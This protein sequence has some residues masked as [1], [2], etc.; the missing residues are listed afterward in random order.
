MHSLVFLLFASVVHSY[1]PLKPGTNL[2]EEQFL[3]NRN[4]TET[5]GSGEEIEQFL[6]SENST[7][8]SASPTTTFPSSS[9]PPV[10]IKCYDI[11]KKCSKIKSL[12]TR[13]EYRTIMVRQCAKTCDACAQF[14]RLPHAARCRDSFHSC[15]IWAKNGFC[16]TTY[17][18]LEERKD[19]CRKSCEDC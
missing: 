3:K 13:Q 8:F 15:P 1:L 14:A 12:C 5:E 2:A 19:S 17:Y 16:H 10:P 7:A 4:E 9:V 11:S 18:T 6:I